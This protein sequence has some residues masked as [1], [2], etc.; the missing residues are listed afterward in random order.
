MT[1]ELSIEDEKIQPDK[2]RMTS[3]ATEL[4]QAN[5]WNVHLHVDSQIYI[6]QIPG[7][8]LKI[9]TWTA[10]RLLKLFPHNVDHLD[11][12]ISDYDNSILLADHAQILGVI[13]ILTFN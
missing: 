12:P 5:A 11:F 10:N 6:S 7:S 1:P 13:L 4:A 2:V 9:F 8:K 3:L